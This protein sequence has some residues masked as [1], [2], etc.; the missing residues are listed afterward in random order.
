MINTLINIPC[1]GGI[2]NS[3]KTLIRTKTLWISLL[4]IV[5]LCCTGTYYVSSLPQTRENENLYNNLRLYD[6]ALSIVRD[7]F[8]DEELVDAQNLVYG[9]IQGLLES[10]DDPHS[11]FLPPDEYRELLSQVQ[12][13]YG[14]LGIYITIRD[15]WLTVIAPIEDTPAF[16]ARLQPGDVIIAIEGK[17]TADISID[18]AVRT[19]KGEPG[20]DVTITISREGELEPFDVTLTREIITINTVKH[21]TFE[22]NI[23]YIRITSFSDETDQDLRVVLD[24]FENQGIENLIIDLRA[25]PGGRLDKAIQICDMFIKEG[26]IVSTRH[27]HAYDNMIYYATTHN[28]IC[29][30]WPMIVLV[31]KGSASASEIF[32]G[33]M[34]DTNRGIAMGTKTFGKGSVQSIIQLRSGTEP[35]AM[36]L[37]IAK[38]FTP[39]GRDIHGLGLEPDIIVEPP[40]ITVD[41]RFYLRKLNEIGIVKD[42][43]Q[44]N[45]DY[46]QADVRR[47]HQELQEQCILIDYD[48]LRIRLN[49]ELHRLEAPP[50][51]SPEFDDALSKA[52]EMFRTNNFP[53]EERV[54]FNN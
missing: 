52:I 2:M 37:T 42:F 51:A 6:E 46:T 44:E 33:A 13:Q 41:N 23:G 24:E 45:P 17:S 48:L 20:T 19:L 14:G 25:N 11:S 5:F 36:R 26:I 29:P 38:Y 21:T 22:P 1:L 39:A 4:V 15:E 54:Y 9:S 50:V 32:C 30:D 16:R 35:V 12:G 34:Q 47:L 8:V 49:D 10:L 18:E 43:V 3:L 53:M 7:E 31:N 40:E 27:R 28:T